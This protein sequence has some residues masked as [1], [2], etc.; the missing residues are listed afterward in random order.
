MEGFKVGGQFPL[1]VLL[2][3]NNIFK[4]FYF[5]FGVQKEILPIMNINSKA[6]N[7]IGRKQKK[8]AIII[9]LKLFCMGYFPQ[10]EKSKKII[11][12][13]FNKIIFST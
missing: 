11:S 9:I 12:K 5:S 7:L 6:D 4:K 10:L 8:H 13:H 1:P 2:C 3:E